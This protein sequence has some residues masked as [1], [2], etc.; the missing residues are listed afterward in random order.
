[1]NIQIIVL[2]LSIFGL[3]RIVKF[4]IQK[5]MFEGESITV[6]DNIFRWT[7]LK[8]EGMAFGF[9]PEAKYVFLTITLLIIVGIIGLLVLKKIKTD[10]RL[11]LAFGFVLGGALGNLY[12]R[13]TLGAVID[14]LDFGFRDYRWPTFNVA[15]SAICL[16]I[17]MILYSSY[18]GG[19]AKNAPYLNTNW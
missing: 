13:I 7:Y 1:M 17:F 8:N 11:N 19:K 12:D 4:I 16:G 6:W 14:F 15:D 18:K 2:C 5:T 3:D 9:L 10:L